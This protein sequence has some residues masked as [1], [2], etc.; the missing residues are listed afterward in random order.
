VLL[1]DKEG[2]KAVMNKIL[3]AE[4]NEH[5]REGLRTLLEKAGFTVK[6]AADG[7]EALQQIRQEEFDLLLVD[8]WMPRM[9]GLE[10]L[11][12][13][14]KT[15]SL[16]A[17]VMTADDTKETVLR[18]LRKQ[19]YQ[20]ITKP[21]DPRQLL[22]LVRSALEASPAP[23][24]IEVVSAQP[25]WVELLVPCDMATAECIQS[26][27]EHLESDLPTKV[28]SSVGMAFHELLMNA[29]EWGGRLN[30]NSKVRIAY[31][32]AEK[33]L[34]YRIADP[35]KGFRFAELAH[36]ALNNPPNRPDEHARVR[37]ERGT[38]PGGLGILLAKAMVDELVYNEAHNEVVM[39]KYLD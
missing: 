24:A 8:I 6:V 1:F 3:V 15:P 22:D 18:A 35:G 5:E 39:V 34:L 30:P 37:K 9:N 29:I 7:M 4:D 20:Y 33:M 12:G 36:S 19:P 2:K 13:L 25:N 28:R 31:L 10:L 32:R 16:K 17:V 11:S 23:S 14:P 38:R 21:F 27:L 26:I